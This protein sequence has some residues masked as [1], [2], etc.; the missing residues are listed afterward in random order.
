M[1]GFCQVQCFA[2]VGYRP[3]TFLGGARSNF[4][5]WTLDECHQCSCNDERCNVGDECSLPTKYLRE[6]STQT[7]AS[8]QHHTPTAA[9]QC[10]GM[11]QFVWI[12][13]QVRDRRLDGWA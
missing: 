11:T 13:H 2:H 9:K 12:A 6:D 7:C 4:L 8:S 1:I 3:D 10:G 5:H